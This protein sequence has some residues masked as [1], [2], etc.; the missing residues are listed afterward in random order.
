MIP[1]LSHGIL[2]KADADRAAEVS[3]GVDERTLEVS[4]ASLARILTQADVDRVAAR[5]ATPNPPASYEPADLEPTPQMW[6]LPDR[7]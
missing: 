3:S 7:D 6:P 2:T 4:P 5:A 1:Y